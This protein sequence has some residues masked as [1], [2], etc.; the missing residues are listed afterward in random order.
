MGELD[1]VAERIS[2]EESG[3][4]RDRGVVVWLMARFVQA[5]S[6]LIEVLDFETEMSSGGDVGRATKEMQ[7]EAVP[8]RKPKQ[9]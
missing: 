1:Q 4:V 9:V 2:A 3:P 6:C 5:T 7:L 8:G